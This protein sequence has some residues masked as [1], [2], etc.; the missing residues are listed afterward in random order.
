L[1]NTIRHIRQARELTEDIQPFTL[2]KALEGDRLGTPKV[3][4]STEALAYPV[5]AFTWHEDSLRPLPATEYTDNPEVARDT[6]PTSLA[7]YEQLLRQAQEEAARCLSEAHTQAAALTAEA[8]RVG[9]TQGEEAAREAAR[10]QATPVFASFQR[11]AEEIVHLRARILRLAEEDILA[12][13]LHVARKIIHQ[14]VL[15]N[16]EVLT[17]TLSRALDRLMDSDS[18]VVRV[19]PIDLQH[20]LE[21]QEDLLRTTG[22]IKALTIQADTTIGRGGCLVESSFGEIDARLEAQIEEVERHFQ[23]LSSPVSEG[24]LA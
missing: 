2:P 17:T 7:E 1:S 13:A 6:M 20:A 11:A 9:F 16:R 24:P 4:R 18:V 23:A 10:E 15:S 12:L 22:G 19:N 14:E 3:I 5:R 8:Y 21:L